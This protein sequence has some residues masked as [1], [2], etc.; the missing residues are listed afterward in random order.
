MTERREQPRTLGSLTARIRNLADTKGVASNRLDRTVANTV[1]GQML[2]PGVVKG[3]TA[4]KLRVGEAASRFTR[5]VDAARPAGVDIGDYVDDLADRLEAGWG[6][7]TGTV[8][9]IPGPRPDGVPDDYVMVPFRVRLAYQD[10]Q[11]LSVTFELGHD[12][13]GST[14]DSQPRVAPEI[15]DMFSVLGLEEPQP[16][17]LLAAEHQIAQKLHACTSVNPDTGGNERAHDLVDLQILCEEED[18][19]FAAACDA[20]NRLFAARRAQ[21]WPPAVIAHDN[22]ASLYA[23]AAEGLDVLD[24]VDA[25]VEWANDLVARIVDAGA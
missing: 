15:V 21:P 8:E 18:I 7:F 13:I 1:I 2:P 22:W 17:P 10:S 5:D 9:Q 24:D 19:D 23:E 12:E 20:G 3:G 25:A 11:W 6:G 14:A 16:V 4:M